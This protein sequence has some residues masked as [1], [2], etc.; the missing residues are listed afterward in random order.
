[1]FWREELE[2]VADGK[3]CGFDGSGGGFSEEVLEF[4]EDLLLR[5]G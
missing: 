3:A 1:L 5:S 2:N 4:G